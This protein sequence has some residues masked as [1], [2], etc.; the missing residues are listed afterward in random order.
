MKQ[1]RRGEHQHRR[2][3]R[4]RHVIFLF[5]CVGGVFYIV[6]LYWT[7]SQSRAYHS[8]KLNLQSRPDSSVS[9]THSIAIVHDI[10]PKEKGGNTTNNLI[11]KR[12]L[13]LHVGPP[14]TG[15]TTV[16]SALK[17][18]ANHLWDHD[19][20]FYYHKVVERKKKRTA[21]QA[22]SLRMHNQIRERASQ[23]SQSAPQNDATQ[24]PF[25][26][27]EF[28]FTELE[29]QLETN[30]VNGYWENEVAM[31]LD[32]MRINE[33]KDVIISAEEFCF[34]RFPDTDFTWN[35]VLPALQKWNVQVVL[36]YRR[37]YEW[38]PSWYFRWYSNYFY[39][40][41]PQ[42][43]KPFDEMYVSFRQYFTETMEE[44]RKLKEEGRWMDAH[45]TLH[46]RRKFGKHFDDIHVFNMHDISDEDGT[47]LEKSF[48]CQMIPKADS[49]CA[50][51]DKIDVKPQNPSVNT[52]L[53]IFL[54]AALHHQFI[55]METAM[56]I[57]Q[58]FSRHDFH[59]AKELNKELDS[60]KLPKKCLSYDDL[61]DLLEL[62]KDFEHY[63][64]PE[65]SMIDNVHSSHES[66]FWKAVEKQKF[67]D[68]DLELLF[69]ETKDQFQRII[70]QIER[71]I[72]GFIPNARMEMRRCP[73]GKEYVCARQQLVH[74][75][76]GFG[77]GK[78]H[79]KNQDRFNFGPNF[80]MRNRQRLGFDAR[81]RK[82]ITFH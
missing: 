62:S 57:H 29:E 31:V 46:A 53:F 24:S 49:T 45:P 74:G 73:P 21:A 2:S 77:G 27:F 14:K 75:T 35:L 8:A 56:T 23:I 64:F 81:K 25:K 43:A 70:P 52:D 61:N 18:V 38:M 48:I 66:E 69:D 54:H 59:S 17:K 10:T 78:M 30:K 34:D 12:T 9:Q 71:I 55:P 68:L 20:Y 58:A 51:M 26:H 80:D 67:C 76:S 33:K 22:A 40:T 72:N 82:H 7:I 32:K 44:A 16:Q 50:Y 11:K 6:S 41:S 4:K 42:K 1:K 19:S 60:I 39:L 36:S 13:I 65:W 79:Y 28:I 3:F 63:I 5:F 15:T 47:S 37:Y